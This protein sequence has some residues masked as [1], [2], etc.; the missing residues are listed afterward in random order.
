MS[1][2]SD[3][4]ILDIFLVGCSDSKVCMERH[5]N[6]VKI[7]CYFL[8]LFLGKDRRPVEI[9]HIATGLFIF[10]EN[11]T[12]ICWNVVQRMASAKKN[13]NTRFPQ[14]LIVH[15]WILLLLSLRKWNILFMNVVLVKGWRFTQTRDC[16]ERYRP[17]Q[18]HLR[19]ILYIW[20]SHQP[21]K[22][23]ERR[24]RAV[25]CSHDPCAYWLTGM[26]HL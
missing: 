20:Y 8:S 26:P 17:V 2:Q 24:T 16:S 7:H 11:V 4:S 23:R 5:D 25:N 22:H 3:C 14:K 10:R 19:E 15:M 21:I 1:H 13:G 12:I 18:H 6:I 9:Y